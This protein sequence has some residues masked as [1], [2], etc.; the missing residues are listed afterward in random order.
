[1]LWSLVIFRLVQGSSLSPAF[2]TLF[3]EKYVSHTESF[4]NIG[5]K[6]HHY[7][8][9]SSAWSEMVEVEDQD[10]LTAPVV[11]RDDVVTVTSCS[12]RKINRKGYYEIDHPITW[13]MCAGSRPKCICKQQ[14]PSIRSLS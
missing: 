5:K 12:V 3:G 2:R 6:Y 9:L 7:F 13:F 10:L 8:K 4:P 14:W 1:M 11:V